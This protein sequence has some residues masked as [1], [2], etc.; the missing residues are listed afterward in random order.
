MNLVMISFEISSLDVV[1]QGMQ[2]PIYHGECRHEFFYLESANSASEIKSEIQ[3]S[4][5]AWSV[6]TNG[7]AAF[8]RERG[9]PTAKK[10]IDLITEAKYSSLGYLSYLK[11]YRSLGVELFIQGDLASNFQYVIDKFLANNS[12]R[13]IVSMSLHGEPSGFKERHLL[14]LYGGEG[15]ILSDVRFILKYEESSN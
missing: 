13:L 3:S 8:L 1:V 6:R 12:L 7:D 10:V 2:A 9:D 5:C 11:E 4:S 15:L 14:R